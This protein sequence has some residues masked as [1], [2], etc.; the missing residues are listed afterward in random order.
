MV[1]QLDLSKAHPQLRR[2][3]A[4]E[5]VRAKIL[6]GQFP[7]GAALSERHVGATLGISRTPVREALMRLQEEGLIEFVPGRGP[8]VRMMAP[9]EMHEI[10]LAREALESLAARLAAARIS[11][12][13]VKEL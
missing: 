3:F 12:A 11:V 5:A 1:R 9:K 7:P 8:V 13:V 2:D 6:S 10:L 4:H